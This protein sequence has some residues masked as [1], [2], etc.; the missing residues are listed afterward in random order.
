MR[1]LPDELVDKI[2]DIRGWVEKS[3]TKKLLSVMLIVWLLLYLPASVY[4]SLGMKDHHHDFYPSG[5]APEG[6]TSKDYGVVTGPIQLDN[7]SNGRF[8][9][10]VERGENI[11]FNWTASDYDS[12][13]HIG[14]VNVYYELDGDEGKVRLKKTGEGEERVTWYGENRFHKNGT[15]RYYYRADKNDIS[16]FHRRASVI[17]EGGNLYEDIQTGPPPLINFLMIPPTLLTPSVSMGGA[18]FSFQIYF[19]LF[20][21][22]NAFI[23]Y[24]SFKDVDKAGAFFAGIL[25]L[26]NPVTL[27]NIHQDE[28]VV[29]FMILLPVYFLLKERERF[30]SILAGLSVPVKV[31]GLFLYPLFLIRK[32]KDLKKGLI[33]VVTALTV[34]ISIFMFFYLLWGEKSVWFLSQYSGQTSALNMG[35][36]S[37]WG[38]WF[39]VFPGAADI[40]SR[41][42]ILALIGVSEL[43]VF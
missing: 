17:I 34:T 8:V 29:A 6:I 35:P 30:S 14:R 38:R 23:L 19:S 43:A 7:S 22:F 42:V 32:D 20:T 2:S 16:K 25:F 12:S 1:Y 3:S 15:L 28:A 18:Y 36:V 24:F 21:L 40:I 11:G 10:E 27:S 13:K 41:K 33:R 37:F 31:W 39:A 9:L 5:A 26:A 4:L